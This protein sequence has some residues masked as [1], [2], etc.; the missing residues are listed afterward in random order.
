MSHNSISGALYAERDATISAEGT[1]QG[2]SWSP[3]NYASLGL[4]TGSTPIGKSVSFR[5]TTYGTF[6]MP[7]GWSVTIG[8]NTT[9]LPQYQYAWKDRINVPSGEWLMEVKL[10]TGGAYSTGRAAIYD[11]ANNLLSPIMSWRDGRRS[12][13]MIARV[14]A[15]ASV[16]VRVVATAIN[17]VPTDQGHPLTSITFKALE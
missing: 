7:A 10:G 11:S 12:A 8:P 6:Y 4:G 1:G 13:L 2:A 5:A 14:S 3:T 15:P 17:I 16:E 9:I